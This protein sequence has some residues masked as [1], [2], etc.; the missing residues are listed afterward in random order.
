MSAVRIIVG[1][2]LEE[3]A[4]AFLDAWHRAERGETVGENVLALD[5]WKALIPVITS[6][7]RRLLRFGATDHREDS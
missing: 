5:S 6:G 7:Y 3:D 1:Y 4:A 2:S